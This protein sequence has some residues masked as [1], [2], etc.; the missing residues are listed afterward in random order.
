MK[1]QNPE[2]LQTTIKPMKDIVI[3][4]FFFF[5][6]KIDLKELFLLTFVMSPRSLFIFS[7][8][9]VLSLRNNQGLNLSHCIN[10][11]TRVP[12]AEC[13]M[14]RELPSQS[15]CPTSFHLLGC[16]SLQHVMEPKH[17]SGTFPDSKWMLSPISV[18]EYF[19][20]ID[21]LGRWLSQS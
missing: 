13:V 21:N 16:V 14:E 2:N 15:L 7:L 19:P 3:M 9:T 1:Q 20:P 17:L 18:W 12:K 11:G 4:L 10:T 8:L 5:D 6:Q